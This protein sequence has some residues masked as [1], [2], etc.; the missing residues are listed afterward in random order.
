[1]NTT[2]EAAKTV[3]NTQLNS[4]I[5]IGK[6]SIPE[7]KSDLKHLQKAILT[8]RDRI[9]E[10]LHND[11]GKPYV[12]CI[13]DDIRPV[14]DEIRNALKELNKWSSVTS[15]PSSLSLIGIKAFTKPEPK[16]VVLVLA[17]FNFPFNLAMGPLV[18]ALAAGNCCMLKPSEFTPHTSEIIREIVEEVFGPSQVAVVQG[19]GTLAAALTAMPFHHIF[20]TG[21]VATGKKVMRAAAENLCSV[22]LELGGKSPAIVNEDADLD[23]AVSRITWGKF[24]NSG[25]VCISPDYALVHESI[26]GTFIKSMHECMA[27]YYGKPLESKSLSNIVNTHHFDRLVVLLNDALAKGALIESGGVY[28]RDKLRFAPTV[29]SNVSFDMNVMNEEIFGPIMPIIGWESHEEMLAILARNDRPLA[30]YGFSKSSTWI[31]KLISDTRAGSTGIN[32]CIIQFIYPKLPFG[33]INAS[34]I[35]KAHGKA[36]FDEF[37]N[38]RSII[39]QQSKYNLTRLINP[40]YTRNTNKMAQLILKWL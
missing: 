17:P 36:G 8:R 26:H 3:F 21:G 12:Q 33:G 22:T 4:Y 14:V 23:N 29:L 11:L 34:G 39:K 38:T 13:T 32:D 35:G 5:E 30:L 28:D 16:G 27:R 6:R 7:R 20:F 15:M 2:I 40:P 9:A 18:S 31:K 19:D 25:Q 24:L 1:M 37:S 10:E